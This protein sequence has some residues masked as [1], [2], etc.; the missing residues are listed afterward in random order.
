MLLCSSATVSSLRIDQ[1]QGRPARAPPILTLQW[2]AEQD[3]LLRNASVSF[4]TDKQVLPPLQTVSK[5]DPE[6]DLS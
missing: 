4:A 2:S 1:D 5:R 6:W 3:D